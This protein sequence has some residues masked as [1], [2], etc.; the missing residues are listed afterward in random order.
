MNTLRNQFVRRFIK[1]LAVTAFAVLMF[2]PAKSIFAYREYTPVLKYAKKLTIAACPPA[3]SVNN[4]YFLDLGAKIKKASKVTVESSN[5]SAVR[6]DCF[7][8]TDSE[9]FNIVLYANE[10][11]IAKV[12]VNVWKNGTK[13]TYKTTV[14]T[15]QYQNPVKTLKIGSKNYGKKFKKADWCSSVK[16]PAAKK[17]ITVNPASGWK[18]KSIGVSG[19]TGDGEFAEVKAKNKSNFNFKKYS[20]IRTITVTLKN[21]NT[22]AEQKLFLLSY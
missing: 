12:T 20:S 1:A 16:F 13:K 6:V 17:K 8:Y 22:K 11:G 7:R 19:F 18:V 2:V 3:Q 10:K 15:V 14:K 21:T 9:P 4:G 5:E